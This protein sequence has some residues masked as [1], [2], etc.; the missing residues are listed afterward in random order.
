[1]AQFTYEVLLERVRWQ[2]ANLRLEQEWLEHTGREYGERWKALQ[3]RIEGL[4][5]AWDEM[6]YLNWGDSSRA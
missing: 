1:M 4:G 2:I 5:L 6:Y 3:A